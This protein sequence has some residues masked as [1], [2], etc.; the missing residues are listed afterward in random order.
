MAPASEGLSPDSTLTEG[1]V[2]PL[3]LAILA[4]ASPDIFQG[5]HA[6][7]VEVALMK[8]DFAIES[9]SRTISRWLGRIKRGSHMMD[10]QYKFFFFWNSCRDGNFS[11]H[12]S[13]NDKP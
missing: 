10:S 7:T 4:I 2:P 6:R 3:R 11:Q 12:A 1:I 5:V 8:S 13:T 9:A